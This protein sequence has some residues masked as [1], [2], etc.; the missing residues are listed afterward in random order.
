MNYNDFAE[1]VRKMID[2]TGGALITEFELRL[3]KGRFTPKNWTLSRCE[4]ML[5]S[6]MLRAAEQDIERESARLAQEFTREAFMERAESGK[7]MFGIKRLEYQSV[8]QIEVCSG[9]LFPWPEHETPP[10]LGTPAPNRAN[11]VKGTIFDAVFALRSCPIW[12]Y[13]LDAANV[14]GRVLRESYGKGKGLHTYSFEVVKSDRPEIFAV[15]QTYRRRG[16]TMYK[17]VARCEYPANYV[18]VAVEKAYR[19]IMQAARYKRSQG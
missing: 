19:S 8:A 1:K 9:R 2:E 10:W 7:V 17:A 13:A 16:T 15:G 5:A 6:E 11:L 14:S 4:P 3:D 12:G 18:E